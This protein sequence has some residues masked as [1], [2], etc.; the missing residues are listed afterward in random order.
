MPTF[1]FPV[2]PKTPDGSVGMLLSQRTRVNPMRAS[3][4]IAGENVWIQ[5]P[6][7]NLLRYT[8]TEGNDTGRSAVCESC[9]S[10]WAKKAVY[11][12]AVPG[13]KSIFTSPW[14][15]TTNLRC[16]P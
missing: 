16:E 7:P 9:A 13:L 10:D 11:L 4:T 3:L 6:P 2:R 14:L 5:L 1:M 12:F 15:L 8:L